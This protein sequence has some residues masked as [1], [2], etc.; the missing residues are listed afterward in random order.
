MTFGN[1]L[2]QP[3]TTLLGEPEAYITKLLPRHRLLNIRIGQWTNRDLE[4][5]LASYLALP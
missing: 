3:A 5:L 4:R 1:L 2:N